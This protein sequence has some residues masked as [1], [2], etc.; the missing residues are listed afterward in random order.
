MYCKSKNE[1]VST[2]I[3]YGRT[4]SEMG[5]S[6]LNV[7]GGSWLVVLGGWVVGWLGGWVVG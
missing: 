4:I 2:A 7:S 3:S 6:S 1:V 5:M